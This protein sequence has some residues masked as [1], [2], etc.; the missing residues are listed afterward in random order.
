MMNRGSRDT[1]GT[2]RVATAAQAVA[3]I[4]AGMAAIDLPARPARE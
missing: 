2:P 4:V 1:R 3:E